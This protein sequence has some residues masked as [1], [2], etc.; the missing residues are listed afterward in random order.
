MTGVSSDTSSG[1]YYTSYPISPMQSL[2]LRAQFKDDFIQ[3]WLLPPGSTVK[4]APGRDRWVFG[5]YRIKPVLQNQYDSNKKE[6]WTYTFRHSFLTYT[7]MT[8]YSDLIFPDGSTGKNHQSFILMPCMRFPYQKETSLMLFY[9]SLF[10]VSADS[11]SLTNTI[12]FT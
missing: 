12:L 10:R 1:F 3:P 9:V 8:F 5:N 11:F 2:I 4:S 7:T 6:C